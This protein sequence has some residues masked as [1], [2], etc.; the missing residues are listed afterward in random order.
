MINKNYP[1]GEF[2]K[3]K[4]VFNKLKNAKIYNTKLIFL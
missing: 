2:L 4:A 3:V 1:V